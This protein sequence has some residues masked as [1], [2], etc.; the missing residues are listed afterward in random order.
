V[1][2]TPKVERFE[3]DDSDVVAQRSQ[4]AV[5]PA[6][7]LLQL[8]A[9]PFNLLTGLLRFVFNLLRIP[10]PARFGG[11]TFIRPL[12]TPPPRTTD[13]RTAAE[14]W[15]RALEEETGATRAN[16]SGEVYA[17][18]STHAGPSS[19]LTHRGPGGARTLPDFVL[20]SYEEFLKACQDGARLGC[21]VLVTD[22]H[23]DVAQFKRGTL[24]NPAF[25]KLLSDN[26]FLVWGGDVRDREAWSGKSNLQSL[27]NRLLTTL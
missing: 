17:S 10:F 16:A 4:R 11:L 2:T 21:V 3:I 15:L 9:L 19:G 24:T 20:S 1:A 25:V 18:G 13:P 23:D 5:G 8:L 26:N 27:Y 6:S 12:S 22:E 14:R 7:P